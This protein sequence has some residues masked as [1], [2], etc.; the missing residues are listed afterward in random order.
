MLGLQLGPVVG[1]P[2]GTFHQPFEERANV[3]TRS[4]GEEDDLLP[5]AQFRGGLFCGARKTTGVV[6]VFG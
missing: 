5:R 6:A 4:A 2:P 3:E 1:V